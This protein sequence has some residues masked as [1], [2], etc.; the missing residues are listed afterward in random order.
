MPQV[1]G[2]GVGGDQRHMMELGDLTRRTLELFTVDSVADLGAALM[3]C[4]QQQDTE[5]MTAFC[6]M[7]G[8]DLSIDWMQMIYQYYL[9]DRAEKKQDYTPQCLARFMSRLIG[10]STETIDMCAGSGAMTIQRWG[11]Y[12]DTAFSLYEIDGNVIPFLVFNMAIRNI[13]ATIYQANVLTGESG[14]MVKIQKGERY[15]RIVNI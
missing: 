4:I 5:R 3:T 9:A 10:D 6:E 15:G 13:S 1:Y 7:V 11:E 12:P 14:T 2:W 8:N